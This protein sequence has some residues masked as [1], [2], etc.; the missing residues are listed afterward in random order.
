MKSGFVL[1]NDKHIPY[2]EKLI[3]QCEA[4]VGMGV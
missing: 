1:N 3:E 2:A 4:F